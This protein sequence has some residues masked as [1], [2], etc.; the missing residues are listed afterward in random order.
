MKLLY[1]I[2]IY[3]YLFAIRFASLFNSKAKL[4]IDGRKNIFNKIQSSINGNQS[5]IV[6]IH[7]ASLGEF[8]QARPLIEKLKTKNEKI[9]ILLTFFSPSGYEVRKNYTG[10]D[11]IFYLP[12]DTPNNA[13]QFIE[14]VKPTA[15]FFVKYEFWFNY[16]NELKKQSIPTYLISG[17]FRE[18][19]YFFKK[20]SFWFLK[21]LHCFTHFFLQDEKSKQLL[22]S[23]GFENT[24]VSGDTRFD[25]VFEIA[26]H[27][28]PIE[29]IA[30]FSENKNVLIAGSTWAEDEKIIASY[31][32]QNLK[33]IIAPHEISEATIQSVFNLFSN[34]KIVR[35]SQA[36]TDDISD[37]QIL[38]IDN[39]G[40]LS[41]VYQYGT[42]AFVG[43]GFGK[44]IHNILEPAT[45][46]LPIVFG[47]KFQKFIE[48]K[49]LIDLGGAFAI[50]NETDFEK[51]MQQLSDIEI[52][53]SA[54]VISK[55]Y[56]A[57]RI[58]ATDKILNSIKF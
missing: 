43:G 10:A 39:I 24:T 56:I 54:S 8:E 29:I 58:G 1:T 7:C 51:T 45:F 11:Y 21:Q 50:K 4:W 6:W 53:K 35:Y 49:E 25:R 55:N 27:T 47:P 33:L 9:K 26:Q 41:S 14:I 16:L 22:N 2:S 12:I 28:K 23:N 30:K 57:S 31:K 52:L 32:L 5:S 3:D 17:I 19:H 44:G 42:I 46:G 48:A 36:K 18:E 15:V 38:I 37:Y 13:K 40:I 20:Y 34:Y